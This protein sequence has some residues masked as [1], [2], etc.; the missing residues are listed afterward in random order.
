MHQHYT[1]YGMHIVH[2]SSSFIKSYKASR[3]YALLLCFTGDIDMIE[4]DIVLGKINNTGPDLPIM[5][6]PPAVTS[7]ISLNTFLHTVLNF[8]NNTKEKKGVKLDFKSI[9]VFEGSLDIL[10]ELWH[11]VTA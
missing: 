3:T 10:H 6:H 8:N 5:G 11:L 4:A 1:T 2:I 7:D 9:E